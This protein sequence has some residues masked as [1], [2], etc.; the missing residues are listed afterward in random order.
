ME[1]LLPSSKAVLPKTG[2]RNVAG[3]LLIPE[4]KTLLNISEANRLYLFI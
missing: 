4:W 3:Q 1:I 2:S